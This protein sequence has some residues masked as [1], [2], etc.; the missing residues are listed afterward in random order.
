[1]CMCERARTC[2]RALGTCVR[3]YTVM[4]AHAC[5]C[6]VL[7]LVCVC[8]CAC[9]CVRACVVYVRV[10]AYMCARACVRAGI[11]C[12]RMYVCVHAHVKG[13]QT[14]FF[15]VSF[16]PKRGPAFQLRAHLGGL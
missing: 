12:A 16:P 4:Y 6:C 11:V 2:V 10:C 7:V 8:V 5:M 9:A 14:R 1:M 15:L 13:L 3:V